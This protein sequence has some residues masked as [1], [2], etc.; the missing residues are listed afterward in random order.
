[1][2]DLSRQLAPHEPSLCIP[3]VFPNI[4]EKRIRAVFREIGIPDIHHID[5]VKISDSNGKP[6]H[7]IFIHFSQWPL[8]PQFLDLR[9]S[10]ILNAGRKNQQSFFTILYDDPWYWKAFANT[11]NHIKPSILFPPRGH[12]AGPENA[13]T[14]P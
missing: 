12:P 4:T 14:S 1:M 11:S 5:F 2:T 3:R 10:L 13:V 8:L 7:R 6:F 9:R